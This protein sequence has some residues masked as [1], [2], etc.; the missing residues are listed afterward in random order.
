MHESE[1]CLKA[2]VVLMAQCVYGTWRKAELDEMYGK[3]WERIKS[4][5][6]NESTTNWDTIAVN[7]KTG[8]HA[9]VCVSMITVP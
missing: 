8:C 2:I 4:D 1:H 9:S 3:E 7:E 5:T 6:D